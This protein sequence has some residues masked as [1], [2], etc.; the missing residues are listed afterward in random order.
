[1]TSDVSLAS[2][3]NE[4]GND[5]SSRIDFQDFDDMVMSVLAKKVSKL[6]EIIYAT[7]TATHTLQ[8]ARC[9]TYFT[10]IVCATHNVCTQY[11]YTRIKCIF[12]YI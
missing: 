11:I 12:V 6:E 8:H 4:G 9:N 7:H 5:A 10:E 3:F 1:M 2:V